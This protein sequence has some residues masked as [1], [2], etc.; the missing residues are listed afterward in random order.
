MAL[1]RAQGLAR[2]GLSGRAMLFRTGGVVVVLGSLFA[3]LGPWSGP[4]KSKVRELISADRHSAIAVSEDEVASVAADPTIAA[5]PFELQGPENVV[6]RFA[7][8]AWATRWLDSIGPGFE[9]LP[10]P[11]TECQPGAMTDTRLVFEFDEPRDI[12]RLQVLGG[13]PRRTSRGRCSG[14][15]ACSNCGRTTVRARTSVL[16]D[17]GEL[18]A[19][20]FDHDD[21]STRDGRDRRGLRGRGTE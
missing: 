21:V 14:G 6:D 1:R 7:N 19:V 15:R 9:E 8:T 5:A 20:D 12:G 16:D 17:V 11:D 3:F 10:P 13:R 2:G 18:V 4:A